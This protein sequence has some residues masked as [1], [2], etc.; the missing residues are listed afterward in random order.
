MTLDEMAA[1]AMAGMYAAFRHLPREGQHEE[2]A[3]HAYRAAIAM[4]DERRRIDR[5]M[6]DDWQEH[7]K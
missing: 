5:I 2:V 1:H 3:Q 4:Q 7:Q 6:K